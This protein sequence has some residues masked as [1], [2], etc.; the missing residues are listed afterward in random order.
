MGDLVANL[1]IGREKC[2]HFKRTVI[3]PSNLHAVIGISGD[4]IGPIVS[5]TDSK[6]TNKLQVAFLYLSNCH[7]AA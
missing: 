2:I 6:V 5:D 3:W 7:R 4:T 1:M